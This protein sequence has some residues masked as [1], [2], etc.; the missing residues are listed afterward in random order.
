MMEVTREEATRTEMAPRVRKARPTEEEEVV[1]RSRW[2]IRPTVKA[3]ELEAGLD[4]GL[5]SGDT[6]LTLKGVL[7]ETSAESAVEDLSESFEK[8]LVLDGVES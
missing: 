1:R 4:Q 5:K 8:K 2:R 7:H 3:Q 6:K